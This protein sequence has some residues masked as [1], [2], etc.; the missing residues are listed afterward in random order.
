MKGTRGRRV[1]T[2]LRP[3]QTFSFDSAAN[4]QRELLLCCLI[5]NRIDRC[6]LSFTFPPNTHT[7][8]QILP[9]RHRKITF[10]QFTTTSAVHYFKTRTDPVKMSHNKGV[11]VGVARYGGGKTTPCHQLSVSRA[12]GEK[13]LVDFGSK[14]SKPSRGDS[15][16]WEQ[17]AFKTN[18]TS[19][20]GF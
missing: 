5:Q 19:F 6:S 17:T 10:R 13:H 2:V 1:E 11:G 14:E 12:Q 8:G 3:R 7:H 20:V 4:R 18:T 9:H 15:I 16:G